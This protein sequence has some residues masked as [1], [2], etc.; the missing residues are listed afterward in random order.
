MADHVPLNWTGF[1]DFQPSKPQSLGR[2]FNP[3]VDAH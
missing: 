1:V 3:Y 2:N